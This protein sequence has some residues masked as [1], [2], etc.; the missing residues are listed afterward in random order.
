MLGD[1]E[2]LE[3]ISQ[4]LTFNPFQNKSAPTIDPRAALEKDLSGFNLF[5][6][7]DF[8]ISMLS[9]VETN[10]TE[11]SERIRGKESGDI[12]EVNKGSV[13]GIKPGI[14]VFRD[15]D[16]EKGGLDGKL[17]E[18][19][20]GKET[21]AVIVN[22]EQESQS[23][24]VTSQ[25]KVSSL[26]NVN[27]NF[28]KRKIEAL[29]DK[30]SENEINLVKKVVQSKQKQKDPSRIQIKGIFSNEKLKSEVGS[31]KI[32]TNKKEESSLK[33]IEQSDNGKEKFTPSKPKKQSS[34]SQNKPTDL[35][36]KDQI[37]SKI[38]TEN[39]SKN[40][41]TQQENPKSRVKFKTPKPITPKSKSSNKVNKDC[42][43][44]IENDIREIEK[45]PKQ[46]PK[47]TNQIHIPKD[48]FIV[49]K[50][51][52]NTTSKMKS[53]SEEDLEEQ[54]QEISSGDTFSLIP[55]R[56]IIESSQNNSEKAQR[57][58]KKT[59]KSK[60]KNK[61]SKQK[62]KKKKKLEKKTRVFKMDQSM[63]SQ[64]DY[65]ENSDSFETPE[66]KRPKKSSK[67]SKRV[68]RGLKSNFVIKRVVKLH[69][70]TKELK[71][72]KL[73]SKSSKIQKKK[74]L[75]RNQ[76]KTSK[77]K[78]IDES[79]F[80]YQ[81]IEKLKLRNQQK[82]NSREELRDRGEHKRVTL[83]LISPARF[84]KPSGKIDNINDRR[85]RKQVKKRHKRY[86]TERLGYPELSSVQEGH[87]RGSNRSGYRDSPNIHF[88]SRKRNR[89]KHPDKGP[90]S[91]LPKLEHVPKNTSK[92]LAL[93]KINGNSTRKK[94]LN[95]SAFLKQGNTNNGIRK[96]TV[97]D[98]LNLRSKE[99]N[100][101]TRLPQARRERRKKSNDF[102]PSER[103][104]LKKLFMPT[105]NT[106]FFETF[107][108]SMGKWPSPKL[109]NVKGKQN[110][111]PYTL[112]E[113]NLFLRR[114]FNVELVLNPKPDKGERYTPNPLKY[115]IRRM[116]V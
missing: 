26:E 115:R 100:F 53:I 38:E 92:Y 30:T 77:I 73:R 46:E 5:A 97:R 25:K 98:Y 95:R 52:E 48:N 109:D 89:A 13:G 65:Q 105:K 110:L 31:M 18:G 14:G 28:Q 23:E 61:I 11:N 114:N 47:I 62:L 7:I 96:L 3:T 67:R 74:T 57:K 36:N 80:K 111:K 44:N 66:P 17:S 24:L 20:E 112:T 71:K 78:N 8:S 102:G 93:R 94:S 56:L 35:Q 55:K 34:Q 81:K 6:L 15:D 91:A 83:K 99:N 88:K 39:K 2:V 68:N 27:A 113:S 32:E 87:F 37:L 85:D 90:R 76:K 64:Y 69:V 84:T 59:R 45:E 82:I 22:L 41:N 106:P 29:K 16:E 60:K 21:A 72:M 101:K 4:Q 10:P 79:V 9:K 116:F 51:F 12:Q 58:S 104:D 103:I 1:E 50:I 107:P 54:S 75:K 49:N 43:Q 33:E 108:V 40:K 86:K 70:D 19:G 63:F 42:N